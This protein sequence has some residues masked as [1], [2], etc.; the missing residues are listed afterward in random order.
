MSAFGGKDFCVNYAAMSLSLP[1]DYIVLSPGDRLRRDNGA[2]AWLPATSHELADSSMQRVV[3][4]ANEQAV[5]FFQ[6]SDT[7][8]GLLGCLK[9]EHWGSRHHLSLEKAACHARLGH[10]DNARSCASRAIKLYRKDGRDWCEG[11]VLLC[12]ELLTAL[13]AGTSERLLCDWRR[14]SVDK[15]GLA[16]FLSTDAATEADP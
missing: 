8:R 9:K 3:E 12:E 11:Y 10:T 14:H 1:R 15:L 7:I 4:M 16:R 5:P 13:E 6:S 2:D